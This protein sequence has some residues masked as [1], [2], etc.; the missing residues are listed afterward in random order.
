MNLMNRDDLGRALHSLPPPLPPA[1]FPV[2]MRVLAS[3]ER[4]RGRRRSS[5][6][7]WFGYCREVFALFAQN[8]MKPLAVPF[9]GGLV[10]AIVLFGV[11]APSLLVNR[12]IASDVPSVLSTGPVL[13]S[14]F[15]FGLADEEADIIVDLI[16]D[17]QGR[18]ID[19]A[20]PVGQGAVHPDLVRGL[21]STLLYTHFAPATVF[22]K[23]A[24]GRTRITLRRSKM[25]VKG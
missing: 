5:L 16:I 23:P 12:E 10:S 9:A 8:L 17:N 6:Q 22:G 3:R 7:S 18:V 15:A 1:G 24:S 2:K 20:I 19:Y 25:D 4:Q 14:S 21:Q 13:K 11:L